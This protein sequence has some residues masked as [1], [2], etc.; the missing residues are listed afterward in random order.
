MKLLLSAIGL[1]LLFTTG[2]RAEG[3]DHSRLNSVLA[4]YVDDQGRVDYTALKANRST[5][6]AYVDA[7]AA[8]SPVSHPDRFSTREDSLAYWINAYNALVLRGVIDAYPVKSVKDI[9]IL[10]GFFNR[11]RF[12][13][14]RE[15][16]T[17]NNIEHDILREDFNEPRIHAAINCASTSC[18]RL[19]PW[20]FDPE[21]IDE[22]L[23]AVMHKFLNEPR[24]VTIDT[25]S[26]EVT[27]SKILDWFSRDF[28]G[29]YERK[30]SVDDAHI[31]DYVA[32]YLRGER[33]SGL[34][35]TWKVRFHEYDWSLNDQASGAAR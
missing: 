35:S 15:S 7:L 14:G 18:P 9:K 26:R 34:D 1:V 10:S 25:T 5:L 23:E 29:W 24:N 3:F 12:T 20:T 4:A 11:T 2:S 17:L 31:L 27:L 22:Q 8:A 16:Y 32:L 19:E 28:T 30:F 21:R 33:A 6:D 13:V